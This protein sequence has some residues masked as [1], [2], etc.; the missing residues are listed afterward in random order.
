[1]EPESPKPTPEIRPTPGEVA[2]GL[3]PHATSPGGRHTG[4]VLLRPVADFCAAV[5][6]WQSDGETGDGEYFSVTAEGRAAL[7]AHL[8]AIGDKHR[9]WIVSYDGYQMEVVATTRGRARYSKWLSVSDV[10]PDLT[11]GDFQRNSTVRAA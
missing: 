8:K 4:L 9:R 2:L 7:A 3:R 5:D 10:R 6:N 11:F 1:P